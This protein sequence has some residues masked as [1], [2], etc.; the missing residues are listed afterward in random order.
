MILNLPRELS[1]TLVEDRWL[2][3]SKQKKEPLCRDPF[4]TLK[5]VYYLKIYLTPICICQREEELTK[6]L[7]V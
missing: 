7:N 3:L 4:F 5:Y 6:S 2:S 1:R